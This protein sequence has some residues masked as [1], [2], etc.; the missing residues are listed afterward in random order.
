MSREEK[1]TGQKPSCYLTNKKKESRF[2]RKNWFSCEM[3]KSQNIRTLSSPDFR[4]G[5][6]TYFTRI[7]IPSGMSELRI[8]EGE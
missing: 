5:Q 4:F 7:I 6:I 8:E 3:D 2:T 1:K